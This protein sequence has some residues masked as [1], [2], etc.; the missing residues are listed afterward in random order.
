MSGVKIATVATSIAAL[1][2]SGVTLKDTDEIP[3]EVFSRHCPVLFPDPDDFI[4]NLRIEP[5]S[6]GV[7]TI[8]KIDVF[9]I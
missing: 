6:L 7:G 4:T 9:Y 1:S 2:V 8:R 5:Q 3:E